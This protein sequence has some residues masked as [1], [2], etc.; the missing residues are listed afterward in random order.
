MIV[1]CGLSGVTIADKLAKDGKRSII[2]EKRDHIGGNC[3]DFIDEETGILMNKYGA[4][5]FHTNDKEVYEYVTSFCKWERWEHTV[6]SNVDGQLVPIPVNITTVNRLMGESI[7]NEEQMK[8]W[9]EENVE[10]Y[11]EIDDSEKMACSRIG[12]VLYEKMVK[13][14]TFK[15]W[16]K[17]PED[18]DPSVLARIPA[19]GNFDTRYFGDKYQILPKNGYTHFFKCML[20]NPMIEVHLNCDFFGFK[21]EHDVH[22]E[23]EAII[24]TGPIDVY[25][26]DHGLAELEYRSI[27]FKI[28][29][30]KNMGYYQT[31]SVVNYPGPEVP[32][33]R[34]VEYKHFLEQ[35]S[36]HTV[37]VSETTNDDGDP[38]YPVKTQ[39]NFDLYEKYRTLAEKEEEEKNVFF[40]GRLANYKYFNM[41]AA[42]RNALDFYAHNIKA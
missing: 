2:I 16:N 4:H 36:P 26:K 38:Y 13:H 30:F 34:I 28:E 29:R 1:G 39:R 35:K 42:I 19:R 40:V 6:L 11:D 33:T 25:F 31:N 23:F 27:N 10:K 3:Y 18:F 32:F 21:A 22:N 9:L 15:Q 37:I 5:L 41:D 20:D 14:Y 8:K 17:Y 7:Q 24:Y 12:R